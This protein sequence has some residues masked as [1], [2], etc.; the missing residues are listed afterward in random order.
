[1]RRIESIPRRVLDAASVPDLSPI[2][3]KDHTCPGCELCAHGPAMLR[4][5]QS[6]ALLEAEAAG[7]LFAPIGVGNGKELTCLLLPDAL[8]AERALILTK[9]RLRDQMLNVDIPR[10]SVHFKIPVERI[11]VL[12][13]SALS[14]AADIEVLDKLH[15]DVIIA[16]ECHSLRRKE[17]MRTRL[18]L[19]Y[20]KL[21]PECRF[22][23]LS[24]TI[25]TNS[26]THY[27]HLLELAL[28][29]NAPL[30]SGYRELQDWARAL[31]VIDP[32]SQE[33][34]MAPGALLNLCGPDAF[35]Q[36]FEALSQEQ[37]T[38]VAFAQPGSDVL[39][40]QIARKIYAR[41]LCETPGVVS[42][43]GVDDVPCSLT[44][45]ARLLE[46]P[47]DVKKCLKHL[48]E[49]WE[50]GDDELMEASQVSAKARQ[51]ACGF[52]YKWDWPDGV[53]D[54]P[55]LAARAAWHKEVRHVMRYRRG[56]H[57]PL[58]VW[59][60]V[61]RGELPESLEAWHLW[62]GVKERWFPHPPIASVWV[63]DYLIS[64]IRSWIS[65]CTE[66][67]RGIVWYQSGA[68]EKALAAAGLKVYRAGDD[69]VIKATEPGICVSLAYK[70]GLN[71]QDRY[72]RSLIVE[73][74]AN[75]GA[76][77]QLLG[78]LH[79]P[80]QPKDEVEYEVY[81]HEHSLISAFNHSLADARFI[82]ET[83]REKQKLLYATRIGFD[84]TAEI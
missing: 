16:N 6:A 18:F 29:H 54:I 17:S 9:P 55:W 80:G 12:G 33:Q 43:S 82:E 65:M 7:G 22:A 23:G 28:R 15:P 40:R 2:W 61:E 81:Q 74:P 58:M 66:E 47:C 70:E 71:I 49:M 4:P 19:E 14:N 79:R 32:H 76:W 56:Y 78:R 1:M 51:L 13:Y 75:G 11:T 68:V 48:R 38:V 3:V 42:T 84:T 45:S 30:P 34:P 21:N 83:Q 77:Q 8:Q 67:S 64:D 37:R 63:S 46:L 35:D 5:I 50:I 57:S 72:H 25:A 73:L 62:R 53:K 59:Q 36:E 26:I 27:S 52:Y 20:M 44:I 24:G 31:D 41:R 10:Y 60:A 39:S 69:E